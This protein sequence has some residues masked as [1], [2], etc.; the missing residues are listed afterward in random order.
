MG[1]A[2]TASGGWTLP[3]RRPG[4]E[5]AGIHEGERRPSPFGGRE[6]GRNGLQAVKGKVRAGISSEAGG[7]A[8]YHL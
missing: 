4:Q 1:L 3:R 2:G 8:S 7:W 6:V 5:M